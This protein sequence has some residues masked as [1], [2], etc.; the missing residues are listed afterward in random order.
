MLAGCKVL[1]KMYNG[2]PWHRWLV[3]QQCLHSNGLVLDTFRLARY[4]MQPVKTCQTVMTF[5]HALS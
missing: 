3:A 2:V 4:L 1:P 5:R